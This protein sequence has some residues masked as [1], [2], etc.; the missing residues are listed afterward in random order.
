MPSRPPETEFYASPEH[1]LLWCEVSRFYENYVGH[2]ERGKQLF[3]RVLGD[4]ANELDPSFVCPEGH[5]PCVNV[6]MDGV[7]YQCLT[8][9][10]EPI[11]VEVF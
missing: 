7:H 8:C 2:N 3:L 4:F 10:W 9:Q 6:S 5:G 11:T 1:A